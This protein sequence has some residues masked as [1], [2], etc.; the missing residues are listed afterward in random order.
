MSAEGRDAVLSAF[1]K[2]GFRPTATTA[3]SGPLREAEDYDMICTGLNL[4]LT[5]CGHGIA[6][7]ESTPTLGDRV[8]QAEQLVVALENAGWSSGLKAHQISGL[9]WRALRSVIL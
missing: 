3:A 5:I 1:A 7:K 8:R 4:F 9:D 2:F 6:L